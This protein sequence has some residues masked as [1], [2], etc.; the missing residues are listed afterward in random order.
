MDML[1]LCHWLLVDV[2]RGMV[3]A[4]SLLLLLLLL[5]LSCFLPQLSRTLGSLNDITAL[6]LS[7]TF[8]V[9][10]SVKSVLFPVELSSPLSDAEHNIN[11]LGNGLKF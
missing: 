7:A 6:V 5:Q 2:W 1:P 11:V 4:S 8:D 9:P 10:E 3:S